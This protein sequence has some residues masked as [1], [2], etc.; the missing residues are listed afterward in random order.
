[1][2]DWEA[3][4]GKL[5]RI[6]CP[7]H[8]KEIIWARLKDEIIKQ[9]SNPQISSHELKK[10]N[11]I[12]NYIEKAIVQKKPLYIAG[13]VI[14]ILFIMIGM[15]PHIVQCTKSVKT[16]DLVAGK[17][18]S[19]V[20]STTLTVA[21]TN[22]TVMPTN[23]V[24]DPINTIAVPANSND[25]LSNTSDAPN[26][27]YEGTGMISLEAVKP[28]V[29]RVDPNG[30]VFE[31]P[32]FG[33]SQKFIIPCDDYPNVL[34]GDELEYEIEQ[35]ITSEDNT[36]GSSYVYKIIYQ[37]NEYP[38][39]YIDKYPDATGNSSVT[40]FHFAYEYNYLGDYI[41]DCSANQPDQYGVVSCNV[42]PTRMQPNTVIQF[43]DG[44]NY[45]ILSGGKCKQTATELLNDYQLQSLLAANDEDFYYGN[46][47]LDIELTKGMIVH[48]SNDGILS[49][50][51]KL[52]DISEQDFRL[53]EHDILSNTEIMNANGNEVMQYHEITL[54]ETP[55]LI[56]STTP[57]SLGNYWYYRCYPGIQYATCVTQEN[58]E[59]D[60]S[61]LFY[62]ILTDSRY[63]LPCKAHVGMTEEELQN[64]GLNVIKYF[65]PEVAL[66]GEEYR[67]DLDRLN[68]FFLKENTNFI[69]RFDFDSIYY[70][71]GVIGH[72]E[73][74]VENTSKST[75]LSLGLIFL[76]K[77]GIVTAIATDRPTA[78]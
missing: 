65:K 61:D 4:Q 22:E 62:F 14:I 30:F 68:T 64:C 58:E 20:K 40:S 35:T 21:P 78:N 72:M 28:K 63:T 59:A 33:L 39:V 11:F 49:A 52:R 29:I 67:E 43:L 31:T 5:K 57:D 19:S 41:L 69:S 50:T 2:P 7:T 27:I 8:R 6:Q 9:E 76:V 53:L 16:R 10:K 46:T 17:P 15:L 54:L 77:D 34:V 73:L 18:T 45:R 23:V 26:S 24:V 36:G 44:E 42:I 74:N 66:F 48:Y 1:M 55:E 12:A 60:W 51:S 56:K 3:F 32:S 70:A 75:N 25:T 13:G 37:E 47:V 38:I 71:E